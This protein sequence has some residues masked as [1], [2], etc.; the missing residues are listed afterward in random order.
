MKMYKDDKKLVRDIPEKRVA[1]LL[2]LGWNIVK[3]EK[4]TKETKITKGES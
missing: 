3:E 2:S 1:L 4:E